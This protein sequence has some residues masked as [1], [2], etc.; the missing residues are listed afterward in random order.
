MIDVEPQLLL[1]ENKGV[2]DMRILF[3]GFGNVAK[4]TARILTE[5]E[6]YPGL[7]LAPAVVGI[8]TQRHGGVENTEGIN[9]K[10]IISNL[11]ERNSLVCEENELSAL[12]PLEAAQKLDYDVL[13][14]LS[15]LSISEHGEPASSYIHAALE[16]GK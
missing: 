8:F 4:E 2:Y 6:R 7:D 1:H 13:V 16:R 15:A 11:K 9:L 12:T 3:I 5:K 10:K 14:E